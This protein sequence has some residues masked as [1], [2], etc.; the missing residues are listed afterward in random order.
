MHYE[1]NVYHN[2][3][4]Q[5]GVYNIDKICQGHIEVRIYEPIKV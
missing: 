1:K 2:G 5:D 3:V 4:Y